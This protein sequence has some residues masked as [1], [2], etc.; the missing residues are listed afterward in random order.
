MTDER[1]YLLS[2]VWCAA[3]REA[4]SCSST[5]SAIAGWSISDIAWSSSSKCCWWKCRSATAEEG[6]CPWPCLRPDYSA[7]QGHAYCQIQVRGPVPRNSPSDSLSAANL[8]LLAHKSKSHDILAKWDTEQFNERVLETLSNEDC[9]DA[10]QYSLL[11]MFLW[12]STGVHCRDSGCKG[13]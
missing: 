2:H 9:T 12:E 13:V 7:R 5:A 1:C 4:S 11:C 8:Y 6:K 3:C 10:G